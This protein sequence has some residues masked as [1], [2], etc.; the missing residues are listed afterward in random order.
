MTVTPV[1]YIRPGILIFTGVI[2]KEGNAQVF[3]GLRAQ[4]VGR[5]KYANVSCLDSFLKR[6]VSQ[7]LHFLLRDNICIHGA[8]SDLKL[9]RM[10]SFT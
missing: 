3:P 2:H 4:Q 1:T 5:H 7:S 9:F 10:F 6:L 8:L